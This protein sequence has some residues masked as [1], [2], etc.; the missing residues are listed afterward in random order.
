MSLIKCPSCQKQI[1]D[2]V[3]SCPHCDFSFNQTE[4]E[5]KRLKTLNFRS[6]RN[7]MFRLKMLTFTAMAIA[8]IG[9]VP[10]LW[11]YAQAIDYGFNANMLK[12]WGIYFIAA[13]FVLY[14][15]VRVLMFLTKRNYTIKK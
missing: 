5:L 8:I 14:M 2:K 4:E 7:K 13:G 11:T 6:Y 12:H 9:L 1:S 10:M 15:V 3:E